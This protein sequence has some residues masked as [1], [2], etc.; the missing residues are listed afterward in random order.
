MSDKPSYLG[1]L[2]AIAVGEARGQTLLEAWARQTPDPAL[3]ELLG[4][5]AIREQEHAAAFTKR[6][7]ELGYSVRRAPSGDFEAQLELMKSPRSDR[8][9]FEALFRFD[10]PKTEPDVL[11]GLFADTTIDPQTGALL[12]R[13]IAEERD[14]DRRLKACYEQLDGSPRSARD[15]SASAGTASVEDPLAEI[16]T[17]LER[18]SST[19]EALKASRTR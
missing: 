3:A 1:L 16:A 7:S 6:L 17:R 18:L 13:F 19:L 9:K 10:Q 5:V 15:T 14:S 8:E 11:S 12:G 4:M 2:N